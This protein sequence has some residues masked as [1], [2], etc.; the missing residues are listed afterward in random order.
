MPQ[1]EADKIHRS[2]K[3]DFALVIGQSIDAPA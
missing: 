1:S 3:R 2:Q